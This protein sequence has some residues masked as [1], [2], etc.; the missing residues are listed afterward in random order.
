MSLTASQALA[1]FTNSAGTADVVWSSIQFLFPD[2]PGKRQWCPCNL[3]SVSSN[4]CLTSLSRILYKCSR[5][6]STEFVKEKDTPLKET[7][8][9]RM[10]CL[11]RLGKCSCQVAIG[12]KKMH[13][14]CA[15]RESLFLKPCCEHFYRKTKKWEGS[16]PFCWHTCPLAVLQEVLYTS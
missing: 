2:Y 1:C 4:V 5:L 7:K 16:L 6:N 3:W 12:L 11:A 9:N 15:G 8:Q 13:E 10:I 14:Q